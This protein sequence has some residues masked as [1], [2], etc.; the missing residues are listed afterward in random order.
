MQM[1]LLQVSGQRK[2]TSAIAMGGPTVCASAAAEGAA[3][4]HFKKARISRAEGGQLQAR[5]RPLRASHLTA[6]RLTIIV[7]S[8]IDG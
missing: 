1:R 5:V 7:T 6:L 2:H 8:K 4:D 3:L